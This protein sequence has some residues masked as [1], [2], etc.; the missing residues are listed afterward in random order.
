M[1]YDPDHY[2]LHYNKYTVNV[3]VLEV[4]INLFVC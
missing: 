3:G 2:R 1:T 4:Y